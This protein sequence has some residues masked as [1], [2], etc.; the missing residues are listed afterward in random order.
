MIRLLLLLGK[1][2]VSRE[3]LATAMRLSREEVE[4]FVQSAHLVVD[5]DGTLHLAPRPH[6]IQLDGE[7]PS[8]WLGVL[9]TPCCFPC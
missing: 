9:L 1:G 2:S 3:Q 8:R 6:Q 5:M 4:A 7:E